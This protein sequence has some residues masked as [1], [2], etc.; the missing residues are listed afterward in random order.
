MTE[1]GRSGENEANRRFEIEIANEL[2]NFANDK[3]AAGV[4][5]AVIAAAFRHAAA[6]FTAFAYAPDDQLATESIME[7]FLQTLEFYDKR[8]RGAD[9]FGEPIEPDEAPPKTSLERLVE[10]AKRESSN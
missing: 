7:E 4:H 10:Q 6:N 9:K 5:P 3:Q 8:H 2:I 1:K